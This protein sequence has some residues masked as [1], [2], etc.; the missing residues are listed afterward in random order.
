MIFDY[1]VTDFSKKGDIFD[2]CSSMHMEWLNVQGAYL[3]NVKAE[4]AEFGKTVVFSVFY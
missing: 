2:P 1:L 3:P 4:E